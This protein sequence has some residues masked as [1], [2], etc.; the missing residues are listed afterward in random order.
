MPL[1]PDGGRKCLL[2]LRT[3]LSTVGPCICHP[4]RIKAR[5]RGKL[6]ARAAAG[7]PTGSAG[8]TAAARNLSLATGLC[9]A[10]AVN[11][12]AIVKRVKPR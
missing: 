10:A 9:G 5:R 6:V 4:G 3:K 7:K 1:R 8:W 11:V 2:A 12:T